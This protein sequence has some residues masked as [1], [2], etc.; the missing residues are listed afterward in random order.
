M[1]SIFSYTSLSLYIFFGEGSVLVF[2]P[3]FNLGTHFLTVEF[4][5][6][7]CFK[8]YTYGF[9]ERQGW[10]EIIRSIP[11]ILQTWKIRP[12]ETG[13]AKLGPGP[14]S[15]GLLHHGA[16]HRATSFMSIQHPKDRSHTQSPHSA[17]HSVNI[18]GRGEGMTLQG[19]APLT[20]VLICERGKEEN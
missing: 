17:W 1:W 19:Q 4:Y 5:N 6:A 13:R 11:L 9:I 12:I 2:W 14:M 7:I 20:S 18:C 8:Q 15:S 16:Y 3:F 10:K